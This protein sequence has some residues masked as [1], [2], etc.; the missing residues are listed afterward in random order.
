MKK[1]LTVFVLIAAAFLT[2]RAIAKKGGTSILHF[3]SHATMS[4]T[5]SGTVE[6]KRNQQG[7][8]DIQK[9]EINVAGL[10]PAATYQLLA[11]GSPAGELTTDAAGNAELDYI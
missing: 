10:E 11:N 6:A 4:G 9:L 2:Q 8:A 5:G 1:T 7:A 3:Q